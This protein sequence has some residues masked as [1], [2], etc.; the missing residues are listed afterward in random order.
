VC[1][2]DLWQAA[3]SLPAKVADRTFGNL[4]SAAFLLGTTEAKVWIDGRT[5]AYPPKQWLE[6]LKLRR[7]GS[8][9]MAILER[10]NVQALVLA[11]SSGSFRP[12]AN[13]LLESKNWSLVAADAGGVLI[14]RQPSQGLVQAVNILEVAAQVIENNPASNMTRGA[15]ELL[16]AYVLYDLAGAKPQAEQALRK[17]LQLRPDHPTLN[18]N[19]GTLLLAAGEFASALKHFEEALAKNNRLAG[20]ALNAGVCLLRMGES[21]AAVAKFRKSL[22]INDQQLGCWVNLAVGLKQTGQDDA[23]IAALE[24]ALALQPD[25]TQLQGQLN[26][27]RRGR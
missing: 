19:L 10:D 24:K 25:N 12:L 16:A 17:G 5:E 6:Y 1:S 13:L 27:W 23:A 22:A 7:G 3:A 21:E 14:L 4:G 2:S 20:S 26:Q 18:H 15:D 11:L 9:A 8:E